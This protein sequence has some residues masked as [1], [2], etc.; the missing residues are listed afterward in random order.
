MAVQLEK[1]FPVNSGVGLT[2]V[3][4]TAT[5][6]AAKPRDGLDDIIYASIVD[7]DLTAPPASPAAGSKYIPAAT[8]T[9]DWTG[10]EGQIA[11]FEGLW[12]FL[13]PLVSMKIWLED[14]AVFQEYDG[15]AWINELPAQ[16]NIIVKTAA[17]TVLTSQTGSVFSTVGAGGAVI[18][19]LP[20]AVVGLE[21][22][23]YVGAA[24]DLRI[25]PVAGEFM[26]VAATGVPGTV[27]QLLTANLAGETAH[28]ICAEATIWANYSI[29]G[30][31]TVAAE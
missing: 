30:T 4:G 26:S 23:F 14:E 18:F 2:N 21:Y 31:W 10:K 5:I 9:G 19:S 7:R 3:V 8:A 16:R 1:K 12:V 22:F 11:I 17:F 28:I 24:Q 13:A 15:A 27:S 25:K 20:A 29:I 6:K